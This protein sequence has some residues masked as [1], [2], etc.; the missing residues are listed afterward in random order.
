[1]SSSSGLYKTIQDWFP[2]N[3]TVG[4][5]NKHYRGTGTI[6]IQTDKI[7]DFMTNT[8]SSFISS[9]FEPAHHIKNNLQKIIELPSNATSDIFNIL[10]SWTWVLIFLLVLII[11]AAIQCT[12]Y[13]C[14]FLCIAIIIMIAIIL[15]M[16]FWA[17]SI[18]QNTLTQINELA[19]EIKC[20]APK[21]RDAAWASFQSDTCQ[22]TET[23][24]VTTIISSFD[25][26]I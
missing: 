3:V 10:F 13:L 12:C 26:T 18:Y 22:T 2:I 19:D 6:D 17:S 4:R 8:S 11:F 15:I 5:K 16:Y 14:W 23:D 24:Q 7:Y 25:D 21:I 20:L 9:S 1:M